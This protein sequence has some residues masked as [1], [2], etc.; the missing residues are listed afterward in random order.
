MGEFATSSGYLV[1]KCAGSGAQG[2]ARFLVKGSDGVISCSAGTRTTSSCC[3][4]RYPGFE[5]VQVECTTPP[6]RHLS[7]VPRHLRG[8]SGSAECELLDSATSEI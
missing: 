6:S 2:I 3:K 8:L 5:V 4:G 1:A 7:D